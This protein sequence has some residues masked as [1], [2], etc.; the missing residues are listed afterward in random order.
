MSDHI[1]TFPTDRVALTRCEQCGE[2]IF[3]LLATAE[4]RLALV[5]AVVQR[6]TGHDLNPTTM[7]GS[8][9]PRT[10]GWVGYL[11]ELDNTWRSRIRSALAG[12]DPTVLAEEQLARLRALVPPPEY[13]C[14]Q[15]VGCRTG[16]T[17]TT[18][19]IHCTAWNKA[20]GATR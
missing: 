8:G 2:T 19:S 3:D 7:D 9:P 15:D 17:E 5:A 20:R 11:H 1:H 6:G 12:E 4:Q 10:G 16:W 18:H 14:T 13:V